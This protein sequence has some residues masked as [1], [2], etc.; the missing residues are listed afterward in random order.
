MLLPTAIIA[1]APKCG[2]TSLFSYLSA[3]PSIC[4][5]I[6]KETYFLIDP[7]YT[8]YRPDR[9]IL[10]QGLEGYRQFFEP[11]DEGTDKVYLEAT[12]DY[13]YQRTPLDVLPRF[14]SL[15]LIIFVLRKPSERIYS[16]FRFAQN[17]V[18]VL[19]QS[20]EFADFLEMVKGNDKRLNKRPI[21][22]N[23]IEHSRYVRYIDRWRAA[24]GEE[25]I[26][27]IIFEDMVENPRRCVRNLCALFDIDTDFYNSFSFETKNSTKNVVSATLHRIRRKYGNLLPEGLLKRTASCLYRF[28]NVSRVSGIE[29]SKED[30]QQIQYLDEEFLPYN[31]KL[32]K[33]YRID[34]SNWR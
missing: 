26:H 12:P 6:V 11:S 21:L 3:H 13:L 31:T 23:A 7:D 15:P 14:E 27:I 22:Q 10:G 29:K 1:G 2:T 4:A 8:L 18:A 25:L 5:S 28:I 32:E 33:R 30:W 34:L 16:L 19:D 24:L 17:N 20:I 9:N